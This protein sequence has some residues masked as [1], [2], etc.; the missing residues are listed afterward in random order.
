M[1][2]PDN[3]FIVVIPK[4]GLTM[5]EATIVEWHKREGEYVNKGEVL[6]TLENEKSTLDIEAAGSGVLHITA[7][8]GQTVPVLGEIGRLLGAAPASGSVPEAPA[9][10]ATERPTA[11]SPASPG[12]AGQAGGPAPAEGPGVPLRASPRARALA[13]QRGLTQ[14]ALANLAASGPRGMLVAA[15]LGRAG[16]APAHSR[17][18][19]LARK[20]AAQAGLD[21]AAVSG[22]GLRG[23]IMR[24]D[25]EDALEPPAH[26]AAPL[27]AA[28]SLPLSGL[29]GVIAERLSASW[30]ER[31]QVTLTTEADATALVSAR[32][33]LMA[34]TG[35][36]VAYDALLVKLVARA[37]QDH[38][39]LNVR[40]GP[41]GIQRLAEINVGVAVDTDRGLLVP[42]VRD[43]AHKSLGQINEEL[44]VL[45][46]RARAGRSLPD[47][48]TGGTFTL[49]TL[50]MFDVDA[51]TPIINPPE[52]AIL[53]VGRIVAKPVALSGQVAVRDMVALSLSFDHRLVDGGPAARCLQR[54]KQLVERP[55]ALVLSA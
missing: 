1:S 39:G 29:R 37:L 22:S 50:G 36:K 7:P 4:L 12:P 30:H 44:M 46:E 3:S 55:F 15:D 6:F 5:T 48:L 25:V 43:V 16:N 38:P 9:A 27:P 49:T 17:A 21:L 53:G 47:E 45:A 13:R 23:M 32:Q 42:V 51:F 41:D 8:A 26:A 14:A 24:K 31:P 54:I 34:E 35:Q 40:L 52:C 19:P 2:E 20:I 10:G 18:S 11:L 28:R 33:Q